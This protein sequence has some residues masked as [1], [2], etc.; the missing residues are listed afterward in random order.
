MI[1]HEQA[2][3]R[4]CQHVSDPIEVFQ[5]KT[6]LMIRGTGGVRKDFVTR[7]LGDWYPGVFPVNKKWQIDE[8][9]RSVPLWLHSFV[10]IC[11]L[12][13][14]DDLASSITCWLR[15]CQVPTGHT[16][17]QTSH[18]YPLLIRSWATE[19]KFDIKI[20]DII[21]DR[22]LESYVTSIWE[23]TSKNLIP[24]IIINKESP[25]TSRIP[26]LKTP[27]WLNPE[28]ID[29]FRSKG[30]D[31]LFPIIIAR[32][33]K[34]KISYRQPIFSDDVILPIY[35]QQ[36]LSEHGSHD[37]CNKLRV[38]IS[39]QA[40]LDWKRRLIKARSPESIEVQGKIYTK[41]QVREICDDF[42]HL[43]DHQ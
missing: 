31:S 4:I 8:T 18:C 6:I 42:K 5:W 10:D 29:I 26:I 14:V 33:A 30:F 20:L 13:N 43:L 22:D 15:K 9:G 17:V 25:D 23:F 36:I 21:H 39:Q 37:I 40:H 7:W 34:H 32:Q 12:K 27:Q 41:Q 1:T 11:C 24:E 3:S 38:S 35:Y 19:Q 16:L 28:E 2:L